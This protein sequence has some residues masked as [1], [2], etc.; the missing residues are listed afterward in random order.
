MSNLVTKIEAEENE[1]KTK[2][3]EVLSQIA[4]EYIIVQGLKVFKALNMERELHLDYTRE[5]I[6]ENIIKLKYKL[7]AKV[8]ID[9]YSLLRQALKNIN[10][11][12][13]TWWDPKASMV[14]GDNLGIRE[15]Y[16]SPPEELVQKYI[17]IATPP[18]TQK[19]TCQWFSRFEEF[20]KDTQLTIDL[21]KIHDDKRVIAS[22]LCQFIDV[23][24]TRENK[25]Y[26]ANSLYNGICAINHYF[27]ALLKYKTP[28]NIHE[29]FEFG[30]VRDV[31][32][33]RM[34]ELEE[35]AGGNYN[36]ADPLSDEEMVKIFDHTMVSSNSPEGLLRRV[37][38]WIG[39]CTAQHG[40]YYHKN[41]SNKHPTNIIPPDETGEIEINDGKWY[42]NKHL[43]RDSL[44]SMLKEI[45]FFGPN[46]LTSKDIEWK[47]PL[48]LNT[49]P[50]TI[51][52]NPRANLLRRKSGSRKI[53]KNSKKFDLKDLAE[54]VS[55]E[56]TA[57]IVERCVNQISLREGGDETKYLLHCLLHGNQTEFED[58]IQ[59]QSIHNVV[60][61]MKWTLRHCSVTIV[62]YYYY[63]ELNQEIVLQLFDICAKVTI[64]SET[65]KMSAH[66][67]VKSLALSLLGDQKRI[68][69]SFDEAYTEWTKCSNACLHLF[70]AYLREK[71]LECELHPKL[72]ILLENYVEN[73]KKSVSTLR[74][75]DNNNISGSDGDND[76][77]NKIINKQSSPTASGRKKSVVH[78]AKDY[79]PISVLR[80]T[81]SIPPKKEEPLPP[82]TNHMM[83]SI[84]LPEVMDN[85]KRRTIVRPSE[86][87]SKD[88][89]RT[90]EQ[91]WEEFQSHG[92]AAISDEFLKIFVSLDERAI[93]NLHNYNHSNNIDIFKTPIE[94]NWW[95]FSRKGF[96][97]FYLEPPVP[98][99]P[100]SPTPSTSPKTVAWEDFSEKGF[101]D[102]LDNVLEVLTISSPT[103]KSPTIMTNSDTLIADDDNDIRGIEKSYNG[104]FNNK[105]SLLPKFRALKKRSSYSKSISKIDELEKVVE[106]EEDWEDWYIID[107]E[108][109]FPVTTHLA[110]ESIDEIFPYVW[111][112]AID[113]EAKD[114][115]ENRWGEWIFVEPKKGLVQECEWIMIEEKEQDIKA[116]KQS[117][118]NY[119]NRKTGTFSSFTLLGGANKTGVGIDVSNGGE[120]RRL[121][122][123]EDDN[124]KRRKKRLSKKIISPPIPLDY[125]TS[126]W[127]RKIENDEIINMNNDN[128]ETYN[129]DGDGNYNHD[130]N[131]FPTRYESTGK[132]SNEEEEIDYNNNRGSSYQRTLSGGGEGLENFGSDY[133]HKTTNDDGDDYNQETSYGKRDSD[134]LGDHY[135]ENLGNNYQDSNYQENYQEGYRQKDDVGEYSEDLNNN[136]ENIF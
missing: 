83:V 126:R 114:G 62:P 95:D 133:Y 80:V 40:G 118:R 19:S 92:I 25:E 34:I 125:N 57:L 14:L 21:M 9:L 77:N 79:R 75:V 87:M 46:S 29:D 22:L 13:L 37:F 26:M 67:I 53:V 119:R 109:D 18:N 64:E 15:K 98:K 108:E 86:L 42:L 63:E 100:T 7:E 17:N 132:Y 59:T 113:D 130:D 38:L 91:M 30:A 12:E 93:N 20:I 105:K 24:R 117:R 11:S 1:Q 49:M 106:E 43:G 97:S 103:L 136:N 27:Q 131:I 135:G 73:R 101:G 51:N 44:N 56:G 10:S 116:W 65:N 127:S 66:K 39:C 31:L 81:R 36:G 122:Y 60:A 123:Y 110:I 54:S 6:E 8:D 85:L 41:N 35:L 16:E 107:A 102:P 3:L 90:A 33:S 70:L 50:A 88:E 104:K 120:N 121:T 48:V 45:G 52:I 58:E 128:D 84:I 94:K 78:F 111:I 32:H 115:E 47:F 69:G 28:F 129:N 124:G 134:D 23:V 76:E 71:S 99:S 61:A 82:S 4:D 55:I 68:F 72:S 2:V 5:K 74:F 89:Q 96:K 112:E